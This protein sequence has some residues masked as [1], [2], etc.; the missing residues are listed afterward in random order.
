[1]DYDERSA[2][3]DTYFSFILEDLKIMVERYPDDKRVRDD[4]NWYCE[5]YERMEELFQ[6]DAFFFNLGFVM[7]IAKKR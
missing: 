1:M 6:D 2:L 7:Y 3:F 4:Y 5:N